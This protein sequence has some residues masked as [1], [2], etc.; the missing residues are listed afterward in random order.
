MVITENI[1]AFYVTI[2]TTA[3]DEAFLVRQQYLAGTSLVNSLNVALHAI[4]G[5]TQEHNHS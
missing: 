2:E 1:Y 4:F 5:I 3:K